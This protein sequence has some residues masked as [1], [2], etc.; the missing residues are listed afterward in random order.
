MRRLLDETFWRPTR[1]FVASIEML[2]RQVEGMQI[3]DAVV[4]RM[5]HTLSRPSS[6]F[7]GEPK[8]AKQGSQTSRE[9]C[10]G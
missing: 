7:G 6:D 8:E 2:G 9:R 10:C 5:V 3:F 1:A 4:S